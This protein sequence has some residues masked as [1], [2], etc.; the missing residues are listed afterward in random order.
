MLLPFWLTR[1]VNRSRFRLSQILA[2][3]FAIAPRQMAD[4]LNAHSC[5][6]SSSISC[7]S[8]PLTA[9]ASFSEN[10]ANSSITKGV[11][12][13]HGGSSGG[14]RSV[15]SQGVHACDSRINP[16]A[17]LAHVLARIAGAENHGPQNLDLDGFQLQGF[18][19]P[20]LVGFAFLT[21]WKSPLSRPTWSTCLRK[22]DFSPGSAPFSYAQLGFLSSTGLSPCERS[23]LNGVLQDS[24][25]ASRSNHGSVPWSADRHVHN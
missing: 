18:V 12:S 7:A 19:S 13:G 8:F 25:G 23:I 20:R 6:F 10:L 9:S 4:R 14:I 22:P 16:E 21:L 3:C 24:T 1:S 5:R 15:G 17:Y 11:G 2:D